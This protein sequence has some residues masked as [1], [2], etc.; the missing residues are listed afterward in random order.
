MIA[1]LAQVPKNPFTNIRGDS[2]GQS[3]LGTRRRLPQPCKMLIVVNIENIGYTDGALSWGS[4]K[5]ACGEPRR[6]GLLPHGRRRSSLNL[7]QTVLH[8]FC[9]PDGRQ[10]LETRSAGWGRRLAGTAK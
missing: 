8:L 1:Y 2:C 6:E 7:L 3:A 9:A 5:T 4:V 10:A